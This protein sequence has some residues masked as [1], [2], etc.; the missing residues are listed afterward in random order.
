[1]IIA[2]E[3]FYVSDCV[4]T[5][6]THVHTKDKWVSWQSKDKGESGD[7]IMIVPSVG[8]RSSTSISPVCTLFSKKTS[9]TTT[10]R[11]SLELSPDLH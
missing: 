10:T 7:E 9:E 8:K 6:R 5:W 4:I 11:S 2:F 1:M 3:R